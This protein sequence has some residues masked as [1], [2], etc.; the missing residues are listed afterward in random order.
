MKIIFSEKLDFLMN[1]TKTTNSALALYTTLDASHIS[2]LR[3]GGRK[4]ARNENYIQSMAAYF[5]KHCQEG[6]QK[7]ALKDILK[8]EAFMGS[9]FNAMSKL[10]YQWLIEYTANESLSIGSFINGLAHYQ[11]KKAPPLETSDTHSVMDVQETNISTY[12]GAEGKRQAVLDFLLLVL[13]QTT[14]QTLLLCS[15][16]D[17]DWLSES[18]AFKNKWAALI[19]QLI[20]RGNKIIII[21]TVN[22]DLDEM[23]AAIMQWMPLYMSGAIE[24]YY[25]PKKRDGLFKRTLFIA[26]NTAAIVS[27]SIGDMANKAVNFFIKDNNAIDAIAEE[28]H[29]YLAL[30]RPLMRIFTSKN[31]QPYFAT[32]SEFE[33]EAADAIIKTTSLSFMTMPA[34][35]IAQMSLR[36]ESTQ[37]NKILSFYEK[38]KQNFERKL[39]NHKFY[40]IIT[41]PDIRTIHCGKVRVAFSDMLGPEELF[42][43]AEQFKLHLAN[44][45]SLL[46]QF[47]N[48]HVYV[49]DD[50]NDRGYMLYAKEDLGVLVARTSIPSVVFAIN[51][52]N[53]TAAFWDYFFDKTCKTV[54][55]K[56]ARKNTIDKI[57]AV[58]QEINRDQ[59]N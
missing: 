28:F 36:S 32:L 55:P 10:I 31:D 41:I 20:M 18:T 59:N 6:Y 7:T 27:T 1:I 26:P 8:K 15:D 4:P 3:N 54:N 57:S 33:N 11:V 44:I 51:E 34:D 12:F 2:R 14:P 49:D 37:K 25:Y 46:E 58:I 35:V 39:A 56:V 21:H 5:A 29:S 42:Y 52:S 22:R 16:E 50:Q 48:Y 19:S 17:M 38:R 13:Q 47:A 30:C 24:P 9:D 23:L 43:S 40:E 45:I 53:M